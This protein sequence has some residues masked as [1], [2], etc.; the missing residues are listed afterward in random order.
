MYSQNLM[1]QN[2]NGTM[3]NQHT[4]GG[5][6][7]GLTMNYEDKTKRYKEMQVKTVSQEKLILMLYD[8]AVKFLN[9]AMA[10]LEDKKFDVVNN[11]LIKVQ[12]ILTE[13]MISLNMDIGEIAQNLYSLY[14]YMY[15]KLVEA[16]IKK[17][18][19]P[20][21]EVMEMIIS[22]REVWERAIQEVSLKGTQP[23]AKPGTVPDDSTEPRGF[24][25]VG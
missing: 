11:N 25:F 4:G 19:V 18:K 13:L 2:L 22:L 23:L 12:R 5:V 24:D 14:Q 17:D 20:M 10:G 8:G 16:N 1:Q 7:A 9:I 21:E 6:P 15:D 3:N